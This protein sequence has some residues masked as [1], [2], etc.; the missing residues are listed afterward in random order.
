MMKIDCDLDLDEN[1]NDQLQE[2]ADIFVKKDHYYK[3]ARGKSNPKFKLH[4][5]LTF[6]NIVIYRMLVW[7][8]YIIHNNKDSKRK[9]KTCFDGIVL[10]V[11]NDKEMCLLENFEA[12]KPGFYY[13]KNKDNN[14]LIEAD[15]FFYK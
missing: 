8:N 1:E 14:I 7:Y 9:R 5:K 10:K 3:S 6:N 2:I 4:I 12:I 15:D 11:N 13:Q